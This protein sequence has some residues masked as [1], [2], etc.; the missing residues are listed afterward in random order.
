M[1]HVDGPRVH[2]VGCDAVHPRTATTKRRTEPGDTE[3]QCT[4]CAVIAY[5]Q[6]LSRPTTVQD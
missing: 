1:W 3:H 4:Y 6:L 5:F 2:G